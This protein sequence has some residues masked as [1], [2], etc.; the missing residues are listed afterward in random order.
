MNLA[1]DQWKSQLIKLSPSER[2]ELAHFLLT[3][4]EPEEEGVERAWDLEASTRATEIR[5]GAAAGRPV[6]E[7]IA[8]LRERF[9]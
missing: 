5:S 1:L 8:D 4:I 9:P 2:V 6:A 7:V 3:S